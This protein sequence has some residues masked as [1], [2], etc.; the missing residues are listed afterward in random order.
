MAAAPI[1]DLR[2]EINFQLEKISGKTQPDRD[3]IVFLFEINKN[4]LSV[5]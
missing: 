1:H 2:N 4:V 5:A 3:Q